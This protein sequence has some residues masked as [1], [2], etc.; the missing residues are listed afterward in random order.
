[1]RLRRTLSYTSGVAVAA[2]ASSVLVPGCS[3]GYLLR[4]GYHQ[5]ELLSGRVPIDEA[6]DAGHFTEEQAE[7]LRSVPRI[8]AFGDQIGLSPVRS[9]ETINP[10]WDRTIFNVSA[11]EPL[12]FEPATWWFPVVGRVPYLGFFREQDVRRRAA[13]LERRGLDVYVRTAG[14]YSTL[15]WFRD[16]IL[17]GM[18]D[19]SE[20]RLAD[21]ILHELTHATVWIPGSV[22]FNESLA[23]FVGREASMRWLISSYGEDHPS[24]AEA[25]ERIEDGHRFEALLRE[26]YEELDAVYATPGLAEADKLASKRRI[27][28]SLPDRA[29]VLDLHHEERYLAK[30]REGTWNNAR[31]VQFRTYNRSLEWFEVLLEQEGGDIPRFLARVEQ[32]AAGA[33]D[34]YAA[35]ALAVGAEPPES[36]GVGR[37]Q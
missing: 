7:R 18:L 33:E 35:L 8:K 21:T 4:Q 31:F 22:E 29:D 17:P 15:G 11:C 13:R 32:I 27:L 28:A 23:N 16:P 14:A 1:M 20:H 30:I 2:L 5:A 9:Y 6:I 36:E 3:T 19:W 26:V 24:V 10:T 25:R 12:A 34:P 37:A